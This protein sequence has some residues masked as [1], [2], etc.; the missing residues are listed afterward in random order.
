MRT[1]PTSLRK[2]PV[3]EHA[4]IKYLQAAELIEGAYAI[5][6]CQLGQ[7]KSGKPYLRGLLADK[8][9]RTPMRAWNT[10][11]E[12]F[13]ELPTDGF[14]YITGQTQPYQGEMQ[15]IVQTIRAHHPTR[16]ELAELIPSTKHDVDA[17]FA[18][19]V[20]LLGTLE[21]PAVAA[22]GGMYL[23]D[24]EL[25]DRFCAAPAAQTLHHAYLGG[26]LEHTLGLLRAAQALLPLYPKVSRDIVL[27]GLFL[28]DLGK[29]DE[30]TWEQGFGYSQD[31]QLVGHIARG[32]IRLQQKID[33]LA[34]DP[35]D[36]VKVPEAIQQVLH[37]IILSH[38][39]VPEFGALKLPATPE[40][41][42]ISMLDNLDAKMNMALAAAR[43][44][45][46]DAAE[47]GEKPADL[48]GD[49]T[50]KVWAL[51]NVKLYRPDPAADPDA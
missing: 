16:D 44:D 42:F 41:L 51:G 49:F 40:A 43:P 15:V 11:E 12:Q 24:G 23:S 47:S 36:P 18:Q 13:R 2:H 20:K 8:T 37:H 35:D 38:H 7:T 25:M 14:V 10:T 48:G 19:V 45:E 4:Y 28:H 26:L 29:C 30:L 27:L 1:H 21:H 17:M 6:N 46:E 22:I 50:E 3:P 34:N 32:V 5:Q 31:G 33:A 9:G 39:G